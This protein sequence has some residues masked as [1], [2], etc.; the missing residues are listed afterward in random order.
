MLLFFKLELKQRLLEYI[1]QA[2]FYMHF[3]S[4]YCAFPLVSSLLCD[5][6][7]SSTIVSTVFSHKRHNRAP[8]GLPST[9]AQNKR[10]GLPYWVRKCIVGTVLYMGLP[11]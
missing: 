4:N 3:L 9:C 7:S 1:L 5:Y 8:C 6:F 11:C 2:V 10:S